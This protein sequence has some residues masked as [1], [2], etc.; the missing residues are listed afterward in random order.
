MQVNDVEAEIEVLPKTAVLDQLHHIPVGRGDD[1]YIDLNRL[2]APQAQQLAFLDHAQQLDL[3]GG[4]H[5][6]D[7]IQAQRAAV[8]GFD[9]AG[10]ADGAGE[11]ALLVAEQFV[12]QQFLVEGAAVHRD[13][14]AVRPPTVL[15][16][17]ARE[18][19]LAGAGFAG[20][21]HVAAGGADLPRHFK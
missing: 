8:G 16:Q 3:H 9:Q 20:D 2:R 12:G 19:F 18:Q 15:V 21:Q 5:F 6:G 1:A 7:F 14:R 4:G 10:L 13:E 11:G 17:I